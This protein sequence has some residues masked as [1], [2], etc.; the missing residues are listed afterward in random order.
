MF[1]IDI[2][3][4][5]NEKLDELLEENFELYLINHLTR[6][7]EFQEILVVYPPS[8]KKLRWKGYTEDDALILLD[9][10]EKG[11]ILVLIPPF[12]PQYL[13]KTIELYDIFQV[14]PVFC[15]ENLLSHINPHLINFGKEGKRPIK[16]YIH[17]LMEEKK[18][19]EVIIEGNWVPIFAFK[20]IGKGVVILY[21]LGS[22]N[23]WEEDLLS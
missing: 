5:F 8:K 21:G 18:S 16:K 11:G 19:I 3:G 17:F 15:I 23:F 20:F 14:S 1:K 6:A 13:E 12:N 9:Y 7:E 10:V 22:S 2:I 4:D